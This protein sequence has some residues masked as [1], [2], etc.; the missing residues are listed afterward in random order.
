MLKDT[1]GFRLRRAM[2]IRRAKLHEFAEKVG[3][4]PETVKKWRGGYMIPKT[5]TLERIAEI[6]NVS[7]DFLTGCTQEMEV[8]NGKAKP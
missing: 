3:R 6:L 8:G 2:S 5:E 7:I 1:F 4:S